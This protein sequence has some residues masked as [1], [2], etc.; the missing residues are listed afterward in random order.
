MF[1]I[2]IVISTQYVKSAKASLVLKRVFRN[3]VIRK[4]FGACRD[5]I[6]ISR[7]RLQR[8]TPKPCTDSR[9]NV[10]VKALCSKPES[11]EFNTR[12][13]EILNLPNPSSRTRPCV[14][15]SL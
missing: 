12:L 4:M 13:G 3:K 5:G 7:R 15:L 2:V 11:L 1:R 9:G 6:E 10:V 8:E 14:L